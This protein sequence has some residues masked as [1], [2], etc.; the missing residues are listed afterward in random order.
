MMKPIVAQCKPEPT[1]SGTKVKSLKGL[2][3]VAPVANVIGSLLT[4]KM[5]RAGVYSEHF[6][7]PKSV[8]QLAGFREIG[9]GI[10]PRWQLPLKS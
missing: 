10:L 1:L 8:G 9:E 7:G 4:L 3:M 6:H 5:K 2:E